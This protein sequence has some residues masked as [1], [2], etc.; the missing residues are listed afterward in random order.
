MKRILCW[1]RHR[2]TVPMWH[3]ETWC[4]GRRCLRC[5]RMKSHPWFAEAEIV[6]EQK[7]REAEQE[8]EKW[9]E[10]RRDFAELCGPNA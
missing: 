5:G 8:I 10:E 7:T 9:I 2:W 4:Y 6:R 1:F 3:N